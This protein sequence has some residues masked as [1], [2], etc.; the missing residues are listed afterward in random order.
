MGDS[1]AHLSL[2]S[3]TLS[4]ALSGKQHRK[5]AG[6]ELGVWRGGCPADSR[7]DAGAGLGCGI[8]RHILWIYG[9]VVVWNA[10]R[11]EKAGAGADSL[12]VG[13]MP[14]RGTVAVV[15]FLFC[16]KGKVELLVVEFTM[17]GVCKKVQFVR[18]EKFVAKMLWNYDN[19]AKKY[20]FFSAIVI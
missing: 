8:V 12:D 4:A 11:M 16:I 10:V 3:G 2:F 7:Y 15:R 1:S 6:Q 14:G 17:H 13:R 18:F 19:F 20:L 9:A 5:E